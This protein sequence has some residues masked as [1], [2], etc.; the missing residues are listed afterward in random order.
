MARPQRRELLLSTAHVQ[1]L[2][3][4]HAGVAVHIGDARV[5]LDQ[6]IQGVRFSFDTETHLIRTERST[7]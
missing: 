6:P 4:A 3:V 2:G 5:V 1:V 7:R